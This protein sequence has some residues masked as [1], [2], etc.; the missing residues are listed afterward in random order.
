MRELEAHLTARQHAGRASAILVIGER[1]AADPG[2]ER[3]T[4]EILSAATTLAQAHALTA[5][6]L[7]LARVPVR[8]R[9]N[10]PS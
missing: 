7:T 6:A 3:H 4:D 2:N 10:R 1:T 5:I 9:P 8:L